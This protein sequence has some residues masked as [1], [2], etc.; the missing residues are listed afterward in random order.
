MLSIILSTIALIASLPHLAVTWTYCTYK[1]N[2]EIKLQPIEVLSLHPT[3]FKVGFATS[4]DVLNKSKI[5]IR[6]LGPH[7]LYVTV[8][9][10]VNQDWEPISGGLY[11]D[12][13]VKKVEEGVVFWSTRTTKE[14]YIPPGT[15]FLFPFPFKVEPKRI[16]QVQVILTIYLSIDLHELGLPAYW[17]KAQLPSIVKGYVLDIY[18]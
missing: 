8:E 5:F 13:Y 10:T 16:E 11:S 7:G 2:L 9:V 3:D 15:G 6:N 4:W 1:S 17:G 14:I 18:T 12:R